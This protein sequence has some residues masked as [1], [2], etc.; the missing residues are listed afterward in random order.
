MAYIADII[1]APAPRNITTLKLMVAECTNI[2]WFWKMQIGAQVAP[3]QGFSLMEIDE[4][5]KIL[6]QHLE[7]NSIAWGIDTGESEQ[8]SEHEPVLIYWQDSQ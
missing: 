7:F 1:N 3:V 8:W 2:L 4:N 6:S 5:H